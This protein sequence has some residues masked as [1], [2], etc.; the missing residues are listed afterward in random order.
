[1]APSCLR[2]RE[3]ES[4]GG[5][6][7]QLPSSSRW[8]AAAQGALMMDLRHRVEPLESEAQPRQRVAVRR[9]AVRPAGARVGSGEQA[10]AHSRQRA[11][12]LAWAV[13]RRAAARPRAVRPPAE[14]SALVE[15][16]R[17]ARR[18]VGLPE[19]VGA[20]LRA[21]RFQRRKAET[22]SVN[23]TQ[24]APAVA[25]VMS[26]MLRAAQTLA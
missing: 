10:G 22:R 6:C 15:Q 8:V 26:S 11:G 5:V 16:P 3:V 4:C 25:T 23:P 20:H 21:P 19:V 24:E 18:A 7:P 2:F 9:Q 14:H 17:E 12:R 1:M 13:Q